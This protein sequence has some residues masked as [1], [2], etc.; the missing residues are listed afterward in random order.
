[1]ATPVNEKS[2]YDDFPQEKNTDQKSIDVVETEEEYEYV[3][4]THQ[5]TWRAAI[6]GSILGCVVAA[7]NLYLGLKIGWTFGAA[8]WGSIFGFLILKAMARV[9][10]TV[11]GPKENVVCQAAATSAGGL[12]SGFVTAIPAMYRMGLMGE[13]TPKDDV[14]SLLLWTGCAAFFGM[15]FAVPLRSHFVINQNL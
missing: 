12:S 5:F 8:L 6:V 15:F 11:F 7:S 4:E 13:N 3:H 9:T 10:G 14:V 1:M 2:Q